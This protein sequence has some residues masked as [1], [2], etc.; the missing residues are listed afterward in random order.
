LLKN[1]KGLA[2]MNYI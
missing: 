2:K 1:A